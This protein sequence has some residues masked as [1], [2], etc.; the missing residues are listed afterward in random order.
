MIAIVV[1]GIYPGETGWAAVRS[2]QSLKV[3]GLE[4]GHIKAFFDNGELPWDIFQSCDKDLPEH[5]TRVKVEL[6][7]LNG[8]RVFVDLE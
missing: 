4:G 2:T 6:V 5:A 8:C 7:E 1:D 3:R